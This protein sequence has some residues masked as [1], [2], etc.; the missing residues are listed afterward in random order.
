LPWRKED[1]RNIKIAKKKLFLG[2]EEVMEDK[3]E[4]RRE[5]LPYAWN[6]TSYHLI[7]YI[8]FEGRYN[9]VYGYHFRLP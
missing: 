9:V 5:I 7:N 4:V 3:N 6:E 1:K 2:G 8:S